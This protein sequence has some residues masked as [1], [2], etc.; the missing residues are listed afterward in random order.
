MEMLAVV[1]GETDSRQMVRKSHSIVMQIQNHIM[2]HYRADIEISA[3]ARLVDRT[4][5]Y[6]SGLFRQVTGQTITDYI[7]RIRIAEACNMLIHTQMSIGEISDY[8]GFCE[9]SYFNKVFRK[10]TGQPPSAYLR[11]RTKIWRDSELS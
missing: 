9:Q 3:L 7:Q 8:L 10:T 2:N 1:N 4:P 6:I 11:E 5:N